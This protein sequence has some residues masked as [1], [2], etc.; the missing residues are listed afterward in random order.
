MRTTVKALLTAV[1]NK[2]KLRIFKWQAY[3]HAYENNRETKLVQRAER[4]NF[5]GKNYDLH[6]TYTTVRRS[7]VTTKPTAFDER[8]F[9]LW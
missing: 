6:H 1:P 9:L 2:S 5:L 7:V 8:D 4:G 3:F